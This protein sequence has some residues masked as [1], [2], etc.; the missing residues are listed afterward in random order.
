[1]RDLLQRRMLAA[2][3]VETLARCTVRT[4]LVF[5]RLLHRGE[6]R[7]GFSHLAMQGLFRLAERAQLFAGVGEL[8]GKTVDRRG[9]ASNL[10]HM[11]G[12]CLAR[13][14][15][16]LLDAAALDGKFRAELIA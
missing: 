13:G 14:L 4:T 9:V 2:Q 1:M 11:P 7:F 5:E 6:R 8:A 15:Q 12:R 3:R 10:P 16:L